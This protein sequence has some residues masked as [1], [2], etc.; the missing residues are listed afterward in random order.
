MVTKKEFLLEDA[1][2]L[3]KCGKVLLSILNYGPARVTRIHKM[4]LMINAVIE[5]SCA[6]PDSHGAFH[7]GGFSEE[8]DSALTQFLE[9]GVA[10]KVDGEFRITEY[11]RQL[12]GVLK[13]ELMDDFMLVSEETSGP[14][15]ENLNTLSDRQLLRLTYLLFPETTT[16]SVIKKQVDRDGR[17]IK[18]GD[19]VVYKGSKDDLKAVIEKISKE[20]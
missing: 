1:E 14:I 8:V 13:K 10:T 19:A 9:D 7:Y 4:S 11:G 15:L 3:T 5:G 12:V 6:K 2:D 17:P 18:V 16:R 20:E